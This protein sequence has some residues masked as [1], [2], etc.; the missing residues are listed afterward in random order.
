MRLLPTTLALVFASLISVSPAGAQEGDQPPAVE[1]T[2]KR[3]PPEARKLTERYFRQIA[4][5][6]NEQPIVPAIPLPGFGRSSVAFA[7]LG[8]DIEAPSAALADQLDLPKGQGIV[9][10]N[11]QEGSA[12]AKAGLK[13]HDILLE[14][15]G[16]AV[17][18][19]VEEFDRQLE[20]LKEDK[21]VSVTLL[22]KGKTET[23]K[24]L[25]LPKMEAN[26]RQPGL[27][28]V[29]LP[30]PFF[31]QMPLIPLP[32]ALPLLPGL[33][34]LGGQGVMTT[35]FRTAD[36]FTARHQEGSL[37]ITLT[38]QDNKVKE[39]RV[40]DGKESN[41]YDSL[42]KLPAAHRDKAKTL[43]EIVEKSSLKIE[44][45]KP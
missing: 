29:D 35:V 37:I 4:A 30:A 36:R 13:P 9:L 1:E 45:Q 12:A 17:S 6:Q 18:R 5:A 31:P 23:V 33:G 7:R 44:P 21:A 16:K 22:R 42:D 28:G 19:D 38:G 20:K 15:D 26:A 32:E 3:L 41:T 14:V 34:G 40:Q 39:I 25:K 11:V 8:A 10:K 43:A 24:E 2:L 27:P